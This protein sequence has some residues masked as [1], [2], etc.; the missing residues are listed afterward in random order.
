M[1]GFLLS[2]YAKISLKMPKNN[3]LVLRKTSRHL[4]SNLADISDGQAGHSETGFLHKPSQ[5]GF[6]L[7][8]LIVAIVIIGFM[9]TGIT[10]L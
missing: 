4:K 7:V 9:V 1:V 3:Q 10:S 6:T 8:E 2:G 5:K